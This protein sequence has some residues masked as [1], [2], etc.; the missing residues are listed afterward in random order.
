M[1]LW[2]KSSAQALHESSCLS[3]SSS[4]D[5]LQQLDESGIELESPE[6]G[7]LVRD[8]ATRIIQTYWRQF[9]ARTAT[10]NR[11]SNTGSVLTPRMDVPLQATEFNGTC[12]SPASS[13]KS[14]V[15]I[16]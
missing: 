4:I 6:Y 2:H 5:G 13:I 12:H 9:K 3:D 14:G 10:M 7:E 1:Q 8:V 16:H 11:R 15:S